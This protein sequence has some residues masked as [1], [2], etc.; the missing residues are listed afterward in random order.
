VRITGVTPISPKDLKPVRGVRGRF[1]VP[2][3]DGAPSATGALQ[4]LTSVDMLLAI[5]SVDDEAERRRQMA[6]HAAA[7]LDALEALDHAE[8]DET[9][10][11]KSEQLSEWAQGVPED[12][13]PEITRILRQIELRALIEIAKIERDGD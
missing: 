3:D 5:A 8:D 4:A 13:H 6:S 11:Q 9:R 2:S 12:G 1:T 10:R 7:G